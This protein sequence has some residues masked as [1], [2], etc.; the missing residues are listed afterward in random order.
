MEHLARYLSR[1]KDTNTNT[2]LQ[3]HKYSGL[4]EHLP[5]CLML[6]HGSEQGCFRPDDVIIPVWA[7]STKHA[8]C[9]QHQRQCH[10]CDHQQR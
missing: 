7:Q 2:R 4:L 9:D 1:H 10:Q 6:R 5:R 8:K 3:K